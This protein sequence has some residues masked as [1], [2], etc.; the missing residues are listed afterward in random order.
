MDAFSLKDR[1]AIAVCALI[2]ILFTA[3]IGTNFVLEPAISVAPKEACE[4]AKNH[5]FSSKVCSHQEFTNSAW[6]D[7]IEYFAMATGEKSVTPYSLRPFLPVVVGKFAQLTLPLELKTDKD[8]LFKRISSLMI[9]INLTFAI[10]LVSIPLIYFRQ[11]FLN[12][13]TT[14]ALIV[15]TNVTTLGLVQTSPFFMLDIASY[16]IF[17]LAA[18]AFFSRKI[19]LLAIIS[20]IGILVKEIS[21]ILLIPLLILW[22]TSS[23]RKL[24]EMFYLFL[25]IAVFIGLRVSVGEDPLSVQHGWN[26]SKGE[27]KTRYLVYHLSTISNTVYFLLKILSGIGGGLILACYFYKVYGMEKTLFLGTVLLVISV[28]IANA[29]LAARVPRI[30][31]VVSPF[32]LFYVLYVIDRKSK[33]N[34]I[35]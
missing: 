10:C 26:L 22:L 28:V 23:K 16:F 11:L 18:L 5:G 20:C 24:Y 35:L 27:I 30:V 19:L 4:R 13:P 29:L 33:T 34:N 6:G 31:G 3:T 17:M 9:F 14:V 1:L 12:D 7:S 21:I 8:N 2:A 15:L 25:P 32:L